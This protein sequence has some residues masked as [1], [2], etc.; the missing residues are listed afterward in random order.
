MATP[1]SANWSSP[2]R[3]RAWSTWCRAS[4][5]WVALSAG[6]TLAGLDL[7]RGNAVKVVLVLAWTPVALAVFGG[8]GMID[9][10]AGLAMGAGSLTGSQIGV[11]LTVLRGHAWVK[12]FVTVT[13]VLF[14]V[15]LWLLG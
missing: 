11:R 13:I 8:A 3:S 9:W 6:T 5:A 7:V 15:R 10:V 4:F 14:A 1:R 12:G 2:S